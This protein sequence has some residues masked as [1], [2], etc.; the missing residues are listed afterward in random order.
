MA[1]QILDTLGRTRIVAGLTESEKRLRAKHKA[2][3][4]DS[5]RRGLNVSKAVRQIDYNE[6]FGGDSL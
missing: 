5:R 4:A 6:L 3:M 1:K 2:D